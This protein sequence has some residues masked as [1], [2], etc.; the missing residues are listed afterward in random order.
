MVKVQFI[1]M[2]RL[3]SLIN[4]IKKSFTLKSWEDLELYIDN[5]F[6]DAPSDVK[7]RVKEAVNRAKKYAESGKKYD[8]MDIAEDIISVFGLSEEEAEEASRELVRIAE[9]IANEISKKIE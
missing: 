7:N 9:E 6:K 4:K 3:L 1:D 8:L 2:L 5:L